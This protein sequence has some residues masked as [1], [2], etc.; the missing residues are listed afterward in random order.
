V[1]AARPDRPDA[2]AGAGAGGIRTALDATTRKA[3]ADSSE[4]LQGIQKRVGNNKRRY[5]DSLTELGR[6][7]RELSKAATEEP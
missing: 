2:P 5:Y 3:L 1:D 4:V 7:K 6:A